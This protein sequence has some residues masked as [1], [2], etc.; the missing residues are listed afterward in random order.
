MA[1]NTVV[2]ETPG[3]GRIEKVFAHQNGLA[4]ETV[5]QEICHE[6]GWLRRLRE[7]FEAMKKLEP[8]AGEDHDD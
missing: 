6:R 8:D 5:K 4:A 1:V 2:C 3:C 7:G